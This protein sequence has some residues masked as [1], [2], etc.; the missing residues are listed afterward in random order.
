MKGSWGQSPGNAGDSNVLLPGRGSSTGS[1]ARP[2]GWSGRMGW[3]SL[4][5]LGWRWQCSGHSRVP[6][7]AQLLPS[8]AEPPFTPWEPSV[9]RAVEQW[10]LG[11]S[12]PPLNSRHFLVMRAMNLFPQ[13]PVWQ[14]AGQGLGTGPLCGLPLSPAGAP[15]TP[16]WLHNSPHTKSLSFELFNPSWLSLNR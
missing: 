11:P 13:C 5:S 14:G 16:L 8:P 15:L 2:C 4:V 3:A 7:D 12:I 9:S 10:E 1:S 6:R